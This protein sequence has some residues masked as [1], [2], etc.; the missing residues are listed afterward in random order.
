MKENLKI[1]Y[2]TL[3]SGDTTAEAVTTAIA[4]VKSLPRFENHVF[5][6]SGI[7]DDVY[8][9]ADLVYPFY[10]YYETKVNGKKGYF[11]L[12]D[13]LRYFSDHVEEEFTAEHAAGYL[14]MMV[15]AIEAI[16]PEIYELY[17]ELVC[18]FRAR[19]KQA[20][21]CFAGEASGPAKAQIGAALEKA[22][23]MDLLLSEKYMDTAK[24]FQA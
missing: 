17:H 14:K 13:Q 2:E 12:M 19:M 22:C 9:A 5:D 6:M 4:A 21:E 15:D 3:K 8:E 7:S 24:S 1:A 16:S 10:M 11:D 23:K 18:L 20:I